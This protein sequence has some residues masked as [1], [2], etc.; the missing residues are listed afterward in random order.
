MDGLPNTSPGERAE[1]A[2]A[3]APAGA[4]AGTLQDEVARYLQHLAVERRASPHTIA[5]Y[6]RDLL[7]F[8]AEVGDLAASAVGS[9]HIRTFASRLHGDGLSPRSV[10]RHLSAVRGLFAHLVR[11]RGLAGNPAL[12]VRAPKAQRRLPGAL[13]ADQAAALFTEAA[14]TPLAKRDRAML[15]LLYG[16][17]LRLAEL[18]AV[19]LRDLDLAG[20]FVTVTGKG[21]KTRIVPLGAPAIAAIRAWLATR[22]GL[23]AA[24]P[25][26]TGRGERR[27]SAR[28]VQL[29]VKKLAQQAAANDGV[30]PHMLRHSF[31]SH[32]LESS[33]DLRAVQELLGHANI[34]TTQ[35]YTHLDFQHL[36]KVYDRAHPRAG[37]QAGDEG[38][39]A[40]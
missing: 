18:V 30:H 15:E 33:G 31:A 14:D 38:N 5:A 12:G 27:L 9:H 1:G 26:F 32:L 29:R 34:G 7:G 21:R 19:D 10:A 22:P 28:S 24:A 25:L 40:P 17:G 2:A 36:A 3:T 13:D 39:A 6:R 23:D 20:G 35:I 8:L 16:S 37:R 4:A 11:R